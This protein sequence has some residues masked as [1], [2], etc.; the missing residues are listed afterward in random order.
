[1]VLQALTKMAQVV[2]TM[3]S[4]PDSPDIKLSDLEEK[5]KDKI[6]Q[7]GGEVGKVE[8]EPIAFGLK[9]LKLIFVMDESLGSTETLEQDIR[10]V[11]G[12]QS[13]EVTDVRRAIG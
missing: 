10:K 8:E 2:V 13:V 12:I 7:V 6:T 4:R 1:V 5:T 3:K 9:A 11:H